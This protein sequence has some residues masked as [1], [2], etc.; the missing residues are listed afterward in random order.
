MPTVPQQLAALERMSVTDL[1]RRY[2][3]VFGESTNAGNR[4]WLI[5]RIA[6]RI[7]SLAEGTLSERALRR[8]EELARDADLRTTAPKNAAPVATG[9]VARSD[10]DDRLPPPGTF[11]TRTYKN[12]PLKVMVL[13]SGF[14]F[15]GT[16]YP[17]LSAAAKA[18]TGSHVNGFAFFGLARKEKA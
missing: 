18:I 16:V 7:Q 14:E 11:L 9:I 5:K 13:K 3:E 8:A 1:R 4:V 6:W 2:A 10:T 12:R 15:E 17:T